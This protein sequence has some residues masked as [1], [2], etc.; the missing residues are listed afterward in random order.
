LREDILGTEKIVSVEALVS[1][2]GGLFR[3]NNL[4]ERKGKGESD[5][6]SI[7]EVHYIQ[8]MKIAQR[9]PA[10]VYIGRMNL[11]NCHYICTINTTVKSLCEIYLC[12]KN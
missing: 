5:G 6:A 8:F 12:Y 10:K 1:A 4:G 2:I 7:I 11:I 9:I 3:G